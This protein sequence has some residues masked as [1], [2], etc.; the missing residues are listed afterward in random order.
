MHKL[1]KQSST[2]PTLARATHVTNER[3]E[4]ENEAKGE[5]R[6]RR[7]MQ[8]CHRNM[9]KERQD[10]IQRNDEQTPQRMGS[11]MGTTHYVTA[12]SESEVASE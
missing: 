2:V 1:A 4:R 3:E 8:G 11:A 12:N 5:D 6:E 9:T 7:L 10:F